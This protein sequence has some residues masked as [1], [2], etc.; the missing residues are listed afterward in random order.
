MIGFENRRE[1][2]VTKVS[3]EKF[4]NLHDNL[5]GDWVNTKRQRWEAGGWVPEEEEGGCAHFRQS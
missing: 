3:G 5:G 2:N 4:L 1:K